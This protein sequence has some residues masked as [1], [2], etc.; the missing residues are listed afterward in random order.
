MQRSS[1]RRIEFFHILAGI[2]AGQDEKTAASDHFPE[3]HLACKPSRSAEELGKMPMLKI[4]QPT[5]DRLFDIAN[6]TRRFKHN[7]D[8][9]RPK[10]GGQRGG[11]IGRAHV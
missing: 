11:K 6:I 1:K 7:I 2:V 5:D 10:S 4:G 3:T 9:M 8:G